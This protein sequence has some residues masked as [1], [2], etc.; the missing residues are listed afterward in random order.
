MAIDGFGNVTNMLYIAKRLYDIGRYELIERNFFDELHYDAYYENLYGLIEEVFEYHHCNYSESQYR[1]LHVFSGPVIVDF[2][3]LSGEYGQR[4]NIPESLN[5]YI[6]EAER[7]ARCHFNFSYCLDWILTGYTK[8][9]RKFHSR[10]GLLIYQD[11]YVDLSQ[12][13]YGLVELYSWFSDQCAVL[14][15]ILREEVK[16]A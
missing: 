5:P 9:K 4:N 7:Q 14:K 2:Y 1:E 16:A 12:L 11:D 13:A 8:P 3:T 15:N 10:L 6:M